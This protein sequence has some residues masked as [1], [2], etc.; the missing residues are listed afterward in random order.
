MK[1]A[2]IL[3]LIML[4]SFTVAKEHTY[5]ELIQDLTKPAIEV[6]V[7]QLMASFDRPEVK[8]LVGADAYAIARTGVGCG[9]G[10]FGG[11]N[12]GFTIYDII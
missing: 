9:S 6:T 8:E 3:T 7:A 1:F 11:L 5:S 12:T 2:Y 4:V 10:V